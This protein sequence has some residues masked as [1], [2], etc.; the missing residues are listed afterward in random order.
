MSHVPDIGR[1]RDQDAALLDAVQALYE[2]FARCRARLVKGQEL[3]SEASARQLLAP[4]A[5]VAADHV[6]S[7]AEEPSSEGAIVAQRAQ[8]G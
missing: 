6:A 3:F 7:D 5:I 1:L 2:A 4:V 8:L